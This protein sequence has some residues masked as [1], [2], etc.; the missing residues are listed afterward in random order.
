MK[1][2]FFRKIFEKYPDIKFHENPSI[3]SR[4]DGQTERTKPVVAFRS[5]ATAPNN[6]HLHHCR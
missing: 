1:I 5:L 4:V 2:E 3:G 6:G